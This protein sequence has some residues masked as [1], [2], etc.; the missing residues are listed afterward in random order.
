MSARRGARTNEKTERQRARPRVPTRGRG[1]TRFAEL[2]DTTEA[3]LRDRS[4]DDVGLYQ[5][6]EAAGVPPASVYHFF[7]TKEA[8][9]AGLVQ[10][11]HE[12][13]AANSR[14]PFAAARLRSWQD[15]MR[16]EHESARAYYGAHPAALKLIFGGYGGIESRRMDQQFMSS[17]ADGMFA[18]Y[19][20][21][22]HMPHITAPSAS[23]HIAL[24]IMDAIWSLS[25]L[26]EGAITDGYAEEAL[27]AC[28]AYC[29]LI[30]P[31]RVEVR[32]AIR[33][34]AA[35]GAD[36]TLPIGTQQPPQGEPHDKSSEAGSYG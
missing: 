28:I 22:F 16:I 10:R 25:Y 34:L 36:M 29:R 8:A 15:L 11:Y 1:V 2:L 31:E 21:V 9:F 4:P 18:R 23:F 20:S 6:A 30:L 14:Q 13:F 12:G 32:Q 33:E 26:K 35:L 27:A 7:P 19:D 24:S 3:L 17:L 5:I